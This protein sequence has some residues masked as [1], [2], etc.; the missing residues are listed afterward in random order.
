MLEAST[1]KFQNKT[2]IPMMKQYRYHIILVMIL[3]KNHWKKSRYEAFSSNRAW[4]FSERDYAECLAKQLD[5]KVQSDH[6]GDNPTLLI[7]GCTLQYHNDCHLLEDNV[8][9]KPLKYDFHNYFS[10]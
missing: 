4:F 2:Y 7:E 10:D 6:F 8:N 5:D 3:S 1:D 9:E